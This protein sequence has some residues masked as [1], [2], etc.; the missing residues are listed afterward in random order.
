MKDYLSVKVWGKS[1]EFFWNMVVCPYF[2]FEF[3]INFVSSFLCHFHLIYSPK[4]NFST[5]NS[6]RVFVLP[7]CQEVLCIF[8]FAVRKYVQDSVLI[9]GME[10]YFFS[11]VG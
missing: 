11:V 6:A 4:L 2:L 3:N 1:M 8:R 9:S 7:F 10:S 5:C